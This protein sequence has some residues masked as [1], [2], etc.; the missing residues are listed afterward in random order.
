MKKEINFEHY[1]VPTEY[2]IL[3]C[4]HGKLMYA[5]SFWPLILLLGYFTNDP[6]NYLT[7]IAIS[8]ANLAMF[9]FFELCLRAKLDARGLGCQW[10]EARTTANSP[11]ASNPAE[12]G[13]VADDAS[14]GESQ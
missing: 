10:C 6:L 3:G 14:A 1:T 9:I 2:T 4:W 11:D 12:I 8:V 5:M 7:I 13:G